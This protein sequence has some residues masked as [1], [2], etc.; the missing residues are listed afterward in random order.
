MDY[1]GDRSFATYT[2]NARLWQADTT[3]LG[4]TIVLDDKS[5]DL[6]ASGHVRSAFTV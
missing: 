3:I 4:A 1:D 6:K 2:G 5:G